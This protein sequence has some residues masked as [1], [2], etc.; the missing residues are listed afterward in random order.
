MVW[1]PCRALMAAWAASPLLSFTKAH[2]LLA[3]SGPRKMVTW[4]HS[5]DMAPVA[6]YSLD[7]HLLHPAPAQAQHTRQQLP[8]VLLHL[9][10]HHHHP[11]PR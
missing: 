8:D 7:S 10:H 3:P 9:N 2:P 6:R 4:A 1:L 11:P 5:V